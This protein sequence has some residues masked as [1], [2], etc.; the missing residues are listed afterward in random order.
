MQY[1]AGVCAS[2]NPRRR[3][4]G[5]SFISGFSLIELIVVMTLM[6]IIAAVG[7]PRLMDRNVFN[8][9]STTDQLRGSLRYAQRIAITRNRDVCVTVTGAGDINFTAAQQSGIGKPCSTTVGQLSDGSPADITQALGNLPTG[10]TFM[11]T[12]TF[13]FTPSGAL[14]NNA[15]TAIATRTIQVR[16]SGVNVGTVSIQRDN[17]YVS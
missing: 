9:V 1:P 3:L 14:T 12:G 2:L 11:P 13:R 16:R 7:V 5:S 8:D 10:I 6:G 4:S 17:G 15:G